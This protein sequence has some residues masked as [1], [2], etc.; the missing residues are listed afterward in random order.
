MWSKE[1]YFEKPIVRFLVN[2]F[3]SWSSSFLRAYYQRETAIVR[4]LAGRKHEFFVVWTQELFPSHNFNHGYHQH[5]K[6]SILSFFS[7]FSVYA[8]MH[9]AVDMYRMVL[10]C[11]VYHPYLH[12]VQMMLRV[13]VFHPSQSCETDLL[14]KIE[15]WDRTRGALLCR[16]VIRLKHGRVLGQYHFH[17]RTAITLFGVLL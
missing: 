5:S 12:C 15:C 2:C 11:L 16:Y 17:R 8:R 7:V 14:F 1:L 3:K 4:C 10:E 9:P 13:P 6:S